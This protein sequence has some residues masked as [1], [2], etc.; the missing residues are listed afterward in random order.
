MKKIERI[1]ISNFQIWEKASI[2]LKNFNVIKGSSNSGKSAIVRAINMVI[3]NDWHKSWLRKDTVTSKVRLVFY[4]GTYI[5]RTRGS[6]NSV[7]IK[8][9]DKEEEV[10]SGFGS[11]YPQEVINFLNLGEE[12]CSYQFDSHFFRSLSPTKRALTLGTFSDLQK[13]DE[14]LVDVQK[15]IRDNDNHVKSLNM[16][17]ENSKTE[18]EKIQEILKAEKAVSILTEA[19]EFNFKLKSIMEMKSDLERIDLELDSFT[20]IDVLIDMSMNQDNLIDG[21]NYALNLSDVESEILDIDKQI[22]NL[23]SQIQPEERCP[24]CGQLMEE[25]HEET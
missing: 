8:E 11:N 22:S 21:I 7:L 17:L 3:N 15:N 13:I 9:L 14:V 24:T 12:N 5:E 20:D 2:D 10:W 16:N 19:Q 1:E 18:L 23:E 25:G 4:D 6:V